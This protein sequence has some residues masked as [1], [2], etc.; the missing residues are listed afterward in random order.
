MVGGFFEGA[1]STGNL[2][3]IDRKKSQTKT[4]LAIC[5]GFSMTYTA[6]SD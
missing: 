4:Q 6:K 2:T 3:Y 1:D 5:M